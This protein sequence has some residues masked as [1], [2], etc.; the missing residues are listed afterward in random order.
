MLLC[1][2][3]RW[4]AKAPASSRVGLQP[5]R[6]SLECSVISTGKNQRA[7]HCRLAVRRLPLPV[8]EEALQRGT[9]GQPWRT[10][11]HAPQ[12]CVEHVEV[13]ADD[14]PGGDPQN[15]QRGSC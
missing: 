13:D 9:V 14:Y 15:G 10:E 5:A 7:D 12:R 4:H 8:A 1:A 3:A 6:V 11:P 2:A